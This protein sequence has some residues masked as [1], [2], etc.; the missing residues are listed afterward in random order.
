MRLT[1]LVTFALTAA[2]VSSPCATQ[3]Q[4]ENKPDS[5]VVVVLLN[6]VQAPFAIQHSGALHAARSALNGV[7]I[8]VVRTSSRIIS[9]S[10]SAQV[11]PPLSAILPDHLERFLLEEVEWRVSVSYAVRGS[12]DFTTWRQIQGRSFIG[13]WAAEATTGVRTAVL[14][15]VRAHAQRVATAQAAAQYYLP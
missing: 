14:S 8:G 2:A 7:G 5:V 15:V 10:V 6:R 1:I 3:T 13:T 11:I 12:G 4:L 9:V